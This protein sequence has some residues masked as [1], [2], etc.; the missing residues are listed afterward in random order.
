M[1]REGRRRGQGASDP[2]PRVAQWFASGP[3]CHT[4]KAVDTSAWSIIAIAFQSVHARADAV[5]MSAAIATP[6]L[7]LVICIFSGDGVEMAFQLK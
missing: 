1:Y 7:N 5:I 6:I 2:A 3:T 4:A